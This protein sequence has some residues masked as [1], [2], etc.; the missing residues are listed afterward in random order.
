MKFDS[1]TYK[2]T[3]PGNYGT[4]FLTVAGIGLL[5][6]AWGESIDSSLLYFGYLNSFVFWVT[7]GLGGLF[8]TLLHHLANATWSTVL[9]RMAE[10]IAMTLPVMSL[11]FIPIFLGMH[12]IYHWTHEDYVLGDAILRRKMGYLNIPFFTIRTVV[13]FAIWSILAMMLYRHSIAQDRDGK[14]SHILKLR[15]L[16]AGGMLLFAFSITLASFDWLMSLDPHWFSTIYGV[17]FFSGSV[18][19]VFS[20]IIM[21]SSALRKRGVL[22]KVISTEHYHDLGKFCF[23]FTI[24]WAYAGFSQ[25]LIQWYGNMPEETA[26]YLARWEGNWMCVSYVIMFGHFAFPFIIL[27]FRSVKR[28]VSV[29]RLVALW[30]LFVH[31]VDLYWLIFP[32]HLEQGPSF[33]MNEIVTLVGPMMFLGGAFL[34]VFWRRFSRAP[35]VPVNDSKLEK[36]IAFVNQ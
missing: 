17:Y 35:L 33:S 12:D 19:A 7:I 16:S 18:L 26:W 15:R 25:Y 3:S 24:F 20:F 32:A 21:I 31:F 22:D 2:L 14:A 1:T 11:F 8:F 30:I 23:A 27:I 10:S 13:V 36:S 9:R 29:L 28:T 4:R 5:V 6:S 34:W